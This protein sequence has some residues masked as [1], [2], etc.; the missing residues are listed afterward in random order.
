MS[1]GRRWGRPAD[2]QCGPLG[3]QRR[4]KR[5][6]GRRR[7]ST[8]VPVPIVLVLVLIVAAGLSR[9]STD[10]ARA[11]RPSGARIIADHEAY[12]ERTLA[13][14]PA[15]TTLPNE[16]AIAA[17]DQFD[18]PAQPS[19]PPPAALARGRFA[20]VKPSGGTWAVMIGIDDYPGSRHD[21][22]SAVADVGD[23]NEA[24]ARM[25]VPADHRLVITN[26]QANAHTIRL[27]AEW[28]VAHAAPEAVAVFFYAGHVR[29]LGGTTEAIVA[30][31]G[32]VVTDRDVG[33]RLSRLR[34]QRAWIGIAA[35]YGGGFVEALGPGRV[36][37]AA[38]PA[39]K[40]AYENSAFGRS[41]LVQ[42]MIREAMLANR[43]PEN[44]QSA[45]EYARAAIARDFPGREPFQADQVGAP[46][47]LRPPGSGAAPA[48]S[49]APPPRSE[50]S[51]GGQPSSPP[52]T[53]NT[54]PPTT[55]PKKC[56]GV[57]NPLVK[58]G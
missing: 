9:G 22:R 10:S 27:A 8:W 29:K 39:N 32:A 26:R 50:P 47:D 16:T 18:E 17:P 28:L 23:V 52:T 2:E 19:E 7:R 3:T 36:L 35:C 38:A 25:G 14:A 56:G 49:P 57:P 54:T 1:F 30:A 20:N 48:R 37:T 46:L 21:L 5:L 51:S 4:G 43:A 31:D 34:A 33:D 53:S 45:F 15:D 41:Y 13:P 40:L 6:R 11:S 42:F 55:E 12:L 24:L 58:C 44:V